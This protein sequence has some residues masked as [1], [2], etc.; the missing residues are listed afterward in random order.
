[1][2]RVLRL[3]LRSDMQNFFRTDALLRHSRELRATAT[4][5]RSKAVEIKV[6]A[7][8]ARAETARLR[9][10]LDEPK[11]DGASGHGNA[12]VRRHG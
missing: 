10:F 4:E 11:P 1:M 3:M 6:Q 8:H 12:V 5:I 9:A 2:L 7:C